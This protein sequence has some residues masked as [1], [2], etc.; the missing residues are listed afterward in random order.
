MVYVQPQRDDPPAVMHYMLEGMSGKYA[1]PLTS[2]VLLRKL[3][4]NLLLPSNKSNESAEISSHKAYVLGSYGSARY[5]ASVSVADVRSSKFTWLQK[6]AKVTTNW[7]KPFVGK[8]ADFPIAF[9][10]LSLSLVF[11]A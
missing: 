8:N 3:Q 11:T 2:L 4:E 6:H 9:F 10:A 1:V 7:A 5:W